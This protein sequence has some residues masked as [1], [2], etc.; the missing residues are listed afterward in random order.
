MH[1]A[2]AYK[3]NVPPVVKK[4]M[5]VLEEV[6]GKLG[7]SVPFVVTV[8]AYYYVFVMRSASYRY[9][10]LKLKDFWDS[11]PFHEM[12]VVSDDDYAVGRELRE[13]WNVLQSY[14][15]SF[16]PFRIR[17]IMG[18]MDVSLGQ[19]TFFE[20]SPNISLFARLGHWVNEHRL[21]YPEISSYQEFFIALPCAV[22][23]R[24]RFYAWDYFHLDKA[25]DIYYR[26][27]YDDVSR[28]EDR[29]AKVFY[30][31]L[32]SGPEPYATTTLFCKEKLLKDLTAAIPS[33]A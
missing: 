1:N 11:V 3:P 28:P 21:I 26:K 16:F 8:F 2:P 15:T 5:A 31:A 17:S 9:V 32:N 33:R 4:T 10:A 30:V 14:T 20:K 22:G 7:M 18:K 29:Y 27:V 25:M 13:V 24:R 19:D 23:G 6:A 12:P